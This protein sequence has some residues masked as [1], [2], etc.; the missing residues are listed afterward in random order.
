MSRA[1]VTAGVLDDRNA[2]YTPGVS[3]K[4]GS[5][6][7][8]S[9]SGL[10]NTGAQ[11]DAPASGEPSVAAT[12]EYDAFGSPTESSGAWSG[13]FGYAGPLGYAGQFSYQKSASADPLGGLMLLG[14]RYYDPSLGRFLSRDPISDGSNWYV[15]CA[16]D[17]ASFVDADGYQYSPPPGGP[18]FP[19]PGRDPGTKW[20]RVPGTGDRPDKFKPSRPVPSDKGGQPNAS[21]DARY[22]HWDLS[23]GNRHRDRIDSRGVPLPKD[24][25]HR[26]PRFPS[27]PRSPSPGG[28]WLFRGGLLIALL[29]CPENLTA[30][31]CSGMN[32]ATGKC[33]HCGSDFGRSREVRFRVPNMRD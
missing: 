13:P 10:K 23:D 4:R 21:W 29:L 17:P 8:F 25:P 32:H 16:N 22:G 20:E 2:V 11:T 9:H 5:V 18:P 30:P 33:P 31:R 15:Y 14:H 6:T 3:E 26:P 24:D 28:L 27:P 19:V 7:T 1:G 12:R